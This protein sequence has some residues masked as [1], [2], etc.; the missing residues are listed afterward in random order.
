M[1]MV[2]ERVSRLLGGIWGWCIGSLTLGITDVVRMRIWTWTWL[3]Q[4]DTWESVARGSRMW[5]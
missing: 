3:Y 5:G 2:W 4:G 1:R